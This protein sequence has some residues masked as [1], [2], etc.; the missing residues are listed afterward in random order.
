MSAVLS[1]DIWTTALPLLLGNCG[2]CVSLVFF[3]PQSLTAVQWILQA[4]RHPLDVLLS[5]WPQLLFSSPFR[6]V[7]YVAHSL[8]L[9]KTLRQRFLG[10]IF[11]TLGFTPIFHASS[12]ELTCPTLAVATE[13]W[14]PFSSDSSRKE[15]FPTEDF[16]TLR[17]AFAHENSLEWVLGR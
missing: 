7:H 6:N 4:V 12:A 2:F 8:P 5:H 17:W 15:F 11:L 16:L 14:R 13:F 1:L 3:F 10:S 9:P